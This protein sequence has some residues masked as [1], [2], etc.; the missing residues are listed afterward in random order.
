M[1][2]KVIVA[3]AMAAALAIIVWRSTTSAPTAK[4]DLVAEP[5]S[6]RVAEAVQPIDAVAEQSLRVTEAIPPLPRAQMVIHRA[7]T[8][9]RSSATLTRSLS[10]QT[11]ASFA[12]RRIVSS[13]SG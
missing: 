8:V 2:R 12:I 13:R 9:R 6:P 11:R 3:V 5:S 1:D 10:R 7:M 4:L